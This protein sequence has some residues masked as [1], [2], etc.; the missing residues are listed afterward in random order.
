MALKLYARAEVIRIL[1][2]GDDLLATLEAEHIVAEQP[3]G[4]T[5]ED[6][7]RL[8]VAHELAELGVNAAGLDVILEMRDHWLTER[9]E[10]LEVI[11][12]LRKK[13]P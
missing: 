5:S 1:R 4:F 10:L 7:E 3:G 9:H 2:I 12:A 8:R 11:E 13:L 6:L